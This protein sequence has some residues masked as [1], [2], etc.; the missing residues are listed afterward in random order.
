MKG[1]EEIEKKQFELI[2]NLISLTNEQEEIWKFHPNNP[3]RIDL[4]DYYNLLDMD[5]IQI[6][7]EINEYQSKLTSN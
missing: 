6:E 4:V 1:K 2:N 5:I 7:S 3:N